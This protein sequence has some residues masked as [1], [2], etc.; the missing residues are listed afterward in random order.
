MSSGETCPGR[1]KPIKRQGIW[2]KS[3]A[4]AYCVPS[5]RLSDDG[6]LGRGSKKTSD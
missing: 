6:D 3:R 1:Q 4:Q 2:E 5:E